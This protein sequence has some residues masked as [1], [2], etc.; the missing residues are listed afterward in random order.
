MKIK[1]ITLWRPKNATHFNDDNTNDGIEGRL[2]QDGNNTIIWIEGSNSSFD[3]GVNFQAIPNTQGFQ[4]GFANV[5][6]KFLKSKNSADFKFWIKTDFNEDEQLIFSLYSQGGGYGLNSIYKL[7][8][9]IKKREIKPVIFLFGCPKV[10]FRGLSWR[11]QK[12]LKKYCY[13]VW[14]IND[15]D[16][17]PKLPGKLFWK[18]IYH[19]IIKLPGNGY[20]MFID[21]SKYS[22]AIKDMVIEIPEEKLVR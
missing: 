18:N 17:V 5:S 10:L 7:R 4:I 13:I 20:N 12:F 11:I 6:N 19:R 2:V 15:D 9:S 16:I 21:H 14:V 1:L 22:E 3:W 8:N